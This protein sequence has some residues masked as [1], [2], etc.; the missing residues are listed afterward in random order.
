MSIGGILNISDGRKVAI[1]LSYIMRYNLPDAGERIV[2]FT[3]CLHL[4]ITG[5]EVDNAK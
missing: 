1:L 5:D 4:P 3:G 2:R